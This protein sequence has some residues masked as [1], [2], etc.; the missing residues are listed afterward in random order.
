MNKYTSTLCTVKKKNP[1]TICHNFLLQSYLCY[2][3]T[4]Y[5]YPVI[6][7]KIVSSHCIRVKRFYRVSAVVVAG[8]PSPTKGE[9]DWNVFWRP[10]E[11][12]RTAVKCSQ[13]P[14]LQN[15]YTND[16]TYY[17]YLRLCT[18]TSHTGG[19]YTT[20][21]TQRHSWVV[22]GFLWFGRGKEDT[23]IYLL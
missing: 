5:S 6:P 16:T 11:G 23:K 4:F 17:C 19:K 10:W 9:Y 12:A 7:K 14:T 13:P 8:E 2:I 3:I 1:K 18:I 21:H 22:S 20:S 15:K